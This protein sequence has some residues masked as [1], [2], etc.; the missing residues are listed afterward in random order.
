MGKL[1]LFIAT[2]LDGYIARPDGGI[3]W[4]EN[5]YNPD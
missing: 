5:M 4:L 1:I 3:D 2:S